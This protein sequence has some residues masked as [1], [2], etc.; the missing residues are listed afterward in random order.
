MRT[1]AAL[2]LHMALCVLGGGE[3]IHNTYRV[4]IWPHNWWGR[5]V[6]VLWGLP[7]HSF[8]TWRCVVWVCWGGMIHKTYRVYIWPHYWWGRAV[9]VLWGLPLHSFSTW[10]CVG[11]GGDGV[12]D[13]LYIPCIYLTTLLVRPCRDSVMRTSAALFLHMALCWGH[14][15]V[16]AL[17]SKLRSSLRANSSAGE[18]WLHSRTST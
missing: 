6:T 15:L 9:T 11:G 7:L 13:T 8:S 18:V 4:Y 3:L 12:S 2:F 5:A 10:R 16:I 14:Q 17:N 1:S